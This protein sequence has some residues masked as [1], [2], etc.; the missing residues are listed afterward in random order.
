MHPLPADLILHV[1]SFLPL[2]EL[3]QLFRKAQSQYLYFLCKQ[4]LLVRIK[5][6]AWSLALYTSPAYFSILCNRD[7]VSSIPSIARLN[8]TAYC[9]QSESLRFA[10]AEPCFELPSDLESQSIRIYCLQWSIIPHEDSRHGLVKLVWQHG[11]QKRQ[12][13]EDVWIQYKCGYSSNQ[14]TIYHTQAKYTTFMPQMKRTF[15]IIAIQVSLDWLR[16]GLLI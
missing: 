10:A 9:S 5:Q 7:V 13:S 8:C 14:D 11:D 2:P 6:Q 15:Q 4:H 1:L 12:L 3:Y 16:K